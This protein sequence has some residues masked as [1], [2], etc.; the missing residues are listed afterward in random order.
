[1]A[2]ITLDKFRLVTGLTD[3]VINRQ[4]AMQAI[5]S[6]S[7]AARL[8]T[9]REFGHVIEYAEQVPTT[10]N[11]V[12]SI[13]SHKLPETGKVFIHGTGVAGLTGVLD[14][15]VVDSDKIQIAGVT[16]SERIVN[17]GVVCVQ[18]KAQ[19]RVTEGVVVLERG[20]VAKVTEVR[21][22]KGDHDLASGPFDAASIIDS[23]KWY[24]DTASPCWNCELEVY[25]PTTVFTRRPGRINP[26]KHKSRRA[27]Q[28]VFYSG[29]FTGIPDDLTTAIAAIS[30]EIA[31]DPSG[32]FQSE[33]YD[34]Y[35]YQRMDPAMVA[36]LPTS[37][38]ATLFSYR[39]GR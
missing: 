10:T 33:N 36:K 11:V 19:F 23:S 8:I 28:V 13:L 37:A 26:V 4:S 30:K 6:G 25:G 18:T 9:G 32:M 20:P 15:T 24:I 22:R 29:C 16:L 21:I 35:S 2:S 14:Y 12:I 5:A 7:A 34:Y 3:A 27:A 38:I 31:Q 39:L 1:M 17:K